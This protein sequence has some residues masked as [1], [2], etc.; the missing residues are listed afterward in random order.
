MKLKSDS[1]SFCPQVSIILPMRNAS[2]TLIKALDSIFIQDYPIQ[3]IILVDNKSTDTSV[4]LVEE[5]AKKHKKFKI[6]ILKNKKDI[7]VAGSFNK[8]VT[9][10]KTPYVIFMHSDCCFTSKKELGKLLQPI[11]DDKK[12][13]ATYGIN[14]NPLSAWMQYSFWE[15]CLLSRDVG[16]EMPG[17]VGKIDCIQKNTFLNVGGYNTEGFAASGGEDADLYL[18][19]RDKGM[20]VE[21][22]AK[23][24]H[25]HYLYGDFSLKDL[26]KKKRLTALTY[27]RLLRIQ[28]LHNGIVGVLAMS[29]KPILALSAFI[30]GIQF[31]GIPALIVFPFL[32]YRRMFTTFSTITDP[33]IIL[34]P[35]VGIFLVYY[36]SFWIV[37]GYFQILKI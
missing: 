26:I 23:T 24:F 29:F 5:Y 10:S 31:L 34:L 13:I 35:L 25:L 15:K 2:S 16:K 37:Y 27:G 28:G 3:E 20:V 6:T 22:S 32:Y 18:R 8:G 9:Y 21:T 19:L 12:V 1:K 33:K 30:P 4:D 11:I 17:M 36:E 14:E 7:K